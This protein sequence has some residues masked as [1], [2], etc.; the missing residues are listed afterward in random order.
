MTDLLESSQILSLLQRHINASFLVYFS[1]SQNN[2]KLP[3]NSWGKKAIFMEI[4]N[5]GHGHGLDE[6]VFGIQIRPQK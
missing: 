3:N 5:I 4:C 1:S 6:K 2:V